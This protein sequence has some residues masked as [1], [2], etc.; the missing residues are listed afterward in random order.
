MYI[1]LPL[2]NMSIHILTLV[3]MG[4]VVGFLSGLFGVGG[5]FLLTPLMIISGIP[6]AMAAA[7]SSNQIVAAAASGATAHYR[8]GNI[9]VK[10]GIVILAGSLVG[11]S[12]GVQ[13]VKL[14]RALGHFDIVLQGL[15]I[16]MLGGIGG[17]LFVESLKTLRRKKEV[18]TEKRS[19][20]F[21]G[22]WTPLFHHLPLQMHFKSL[23]AEISVFVPITAGIIIGF[24]SA[25]MGIG[26]SFIMVP[27]LIYI[28]GM[29]TVMAIG[30]DLFQVVISNA[31]ITIQQA[32]RN[33]TVDVVLAF[34]LF[35]GV[36]LGAQ[37]G[38]RT[39]RFLRGE[40]IR[41]VMAIF[42]LSMMAKLIINLL[43][44]HDHGIV[45]AY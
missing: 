11:G 6:P 29:P 42:V 21:S 12:M 44:P 20:P 41:M 1:Y 37:I 3:G 31:N 5:G 4:C 7:S 24:L 35:C 36:V 15:Y 23:G 33:H 10:M 13:V 2:A 32:A 28:I 45:P 19:V 30:T 22:K 9:D 39:G 16:V 38:A 34:S 43:L 40:Q 14:L 8:M 17:L 27:I 25:L 26:G 18:F